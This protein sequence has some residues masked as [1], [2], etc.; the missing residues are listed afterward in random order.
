MKLFSLA[1]VD[2]PSSGK[3]FKAFFLPIHWLEKRVH[4]TEAGHFLLLDYNTH[5]DSQRDVTF[6]KKI[7]SSKRFQ[8]FSYYI[9]YDPTNL[10]LDTDCVSFQCQVQK[11]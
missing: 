4:S 1:K 3:Q 10:A 11:K 8:S 9:I 7:G 6:T 2:K 5:S